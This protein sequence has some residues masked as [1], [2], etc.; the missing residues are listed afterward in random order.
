MSRPYPHFT[1]PETVRTKALAAGAAGALLLTSCSPPAAPPT[2][3]PTATSYPSGHIHGMS[4]DPATN[5][6]L[7][8]THDG[9][10]NISTSPISK[11][12][13]TIDL[14][15][16]TTTANGDF[17]AS[18]HPGQGTDLPDPVG[19]IRS[20]DGG[21]TWQPLS[22]QGES[23]FHALAA[24]DSGI[25]GYDG[26][27]RT[28]EDGTSWGAVNMSV[29]AFNLA[30]T[31]RD[32]VVLATTEEGLQRSTDDGRTWS[33]VPGAPLLMLTALSEGKATGITPEGV[34]YTS[35]NAGVTWVE[36]GAVPGE[37]A[38][39]AAHT[40]D[41]TTLRIWVATGDSVQVSN[42]NGQ[43]FTDARSNHL[44]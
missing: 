42:D 19:L 43:T 1:H 18:G 23:D 4:V 16:F 36:R 22:R 7:L 21:Q 30:A 5:Q 17:Y 12:G 9:L 2:E 8:A 32:S 14:M 24:T 31:P 11:I 28:S 41:D 33:A 38:A 20:T 35:G 26:Q 44:K 37:P 3:A 13:P 10:F 40:L 25:V 27:L 15:G 29:P 6:V 34:V 39:I